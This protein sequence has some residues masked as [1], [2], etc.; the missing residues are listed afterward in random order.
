MN[1]QHSHD[2][3]PWFTL[4]F[5]VRTAIAWR[6]ITKA[7]SV[8]A[9]GQLFTLSIYH[10]NLLTSAHS[11]KFNILRPL[12]PPS[13]F[14]DPPSFFRPAPGE[15]KNFPSHLKKFCASAPALSTDAPG[16]PTRTRA[17]FDSGAGA[18]SWKRARAFGCR[19]A[20]WPSGWPLWAVGCGL[21]CRLEAGGCAP[22]AVICWPLPCGLWLSPAGWRPVVGCMAG[23]LAGGCAPLPCAGAGGGCQFSPCWGAIGGVYIKLPGDYTGRVKLPRRGCPSPRR[24]VFAAVPARCRR[25]EE[26]R[27]HGPPVPLSAGPPVGG[28]LVFFLALASCLPACWSCPPSRTA[29]RKPPEKTRRIFPAHLPDASRRRSGSRTSPRLHVSR[30]AGP[31]RHAG[32]HAGGCENFQQFFRRGILRARSKSCF[33]VY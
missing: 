31:D 2:F 27:H 14:F 13:S 15:V 8:S 29:P 5:L 28:P 17:R 23:L 22:A 6:E 1:R 19:R 11:Q 32:N 18:F 9:A 33:L 24:S 25:L 20:G 21:R 10:G 26:G 4:P 3:R 7:R 16:V 12:M 30:R